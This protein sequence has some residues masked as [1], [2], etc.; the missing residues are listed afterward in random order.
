M[1][2]TNPTPDFIIHAGE[3]ATMWGFEPKTDLAIDFLQEIGGEDWLRSS[4]EHPQDASK[5]WMGN[6]FYTDH[7]P[8]RD[9]ARYMVGEGF[10]VMHPVYGYFGG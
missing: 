9:L 2:N 1:T 7:R 5:Q 4:C 10:V 6:I 3:W 8:A